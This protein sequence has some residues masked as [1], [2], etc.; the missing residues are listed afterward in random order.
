[1]TAMATGMRIGWRNPTTVA[2]SQTRKMAMVINTMMKKAVSAAHIVLRCH[3]VGD[4]VIR[5]FSRT[6]ARSPVDFSRGPLADHRLGLLDFFRQQLVGGTECR[7][8]L[9][10]LERLRIA[11]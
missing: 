3:G 1:M 11:I 7:G 6:P 5:S 9:P 4:L 8:F 10:K 2:R